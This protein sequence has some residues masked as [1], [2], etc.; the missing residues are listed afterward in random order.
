MTNTDYD[1]GT[2]RSPA[3][4]LAVPLVAALVVASLWGAA[5]ARQSRA[6][7]PKP[8]RPQIIAQTGIPVQTTPA[9]RMDVVQSVEVTGSLAA[10]DTVT[11]SPKVPGKVA[12]VAVRPGD[13]VSAG[14]VVVKLDDTDAVNTVRQSESSLNQALTNVRTAESGVQVAKAGLEQAEARQ[15]Q[16][17]TALR[18]QETQSSTSIEQAKAALDSAKARL[19]MLKKGAREQERLS[20]QYA[21][22]QAKANLNNAQS[23]LRRM[24][25][26]FREG[27]IA[28]SQL[29]QAQTQYEVAKAAYET[30][31]QQASLVHEGPRT[32]EIRAAEA[33]VAQAEE[34]VKMAR[35]AAAQ[36]EVRREDVRNARAAVIQARATLLQAQDSVSRARDAVRQARAALAIARE[37]LR[38][39]SITS[40]ING[41]VSRRFTEPGQIA[42]P[43]TPLLEIVDLGTVYFEANVSETEIGR[44]KVGQPVTVRVDAYPTETFR[45]SVLRIYPAASASGRTF[46]LRIAIPNPGLRLRPGM[47]ARG[48]I[49]VSRTSQ[50]LTVPTE[51]VVVRDG[52]QVVFVAEGR[53]A[54][55]VP[56]TTGAVT[57]HSVQIL[58]PAQIKEGDQ[59][60]ITGQHEVQDGSRILVTNR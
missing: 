25:Q 28:Q 44:I 22:A 37:N 16:A 57:D 43:G 18:V 19:D 53:K 52:R 20:A 54:K 1:I 46:G 23:N 26:L 59:I 7:K 29:D 55:M 24:Q 12:Y 14:Q 6:P 48:K 34:G 11:L 56:V 39:M 40:P 27:A 47:F 4:R 21:V 17:E 35:A 5:R 32:E 45:G 3:S 2:R 41:W 42:S 60:I 9:T 31:V 15:R 51:A 13:P 50:S 33:A 58:E 36:D 49:E 38:N 8:T 30:A 10:L